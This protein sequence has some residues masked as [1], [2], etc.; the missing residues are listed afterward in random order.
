[1][2]S[3]KGQFSPDLPQFENISTLQT[4]LTKENA[5]I[6]NRVAALE[7]KINEPEGLQQNEG[8]TEALGHSL[9]ELERT[10][11]Q[12]EGEELEKIVIFNTYNNLT[13]F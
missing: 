10:L 11:C 7:K 9:G 13:I 6:L 1:M 3:L 12:L 5:V 4:Q 8:M 2:N